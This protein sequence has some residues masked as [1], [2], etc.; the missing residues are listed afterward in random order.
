MTLVDAY[1]APRQLEGVGVFAIGM[2][3][4]R[5]C[6]WTFDGR[7][8]RLFLPERDDGNEAGLFMAAAMTA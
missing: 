6:I 4:A 8:D 3:P 2:I 5:T 7:F 1:V